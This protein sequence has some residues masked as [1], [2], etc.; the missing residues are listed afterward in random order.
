MASQGIP[1][2]NRAPTTPTTWKSNIQIR[3]EV[4]KQNMLFSLLSVKTWIQSYVLYCAKSLQS[5]PIL[6]DPMD[7]SPPGFSVHRILQ[8]RI[9]EW[10]AMPSS[11]GIFPTQ[12]SNLCLLCLLLRQAS[13][14][15][16]AAPG[17]PS[18]NQSPSLCLG[19]CRMARVPAFPQ[20]S[21]LCE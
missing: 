12:G 13:S 20:K 6:Y 9:L 11:R 16:L 14:S 7:C 10:D 2:G 3:E 18:G 4:R 21:S 5:C 17:R 8:A 19:N 15:L 1:L